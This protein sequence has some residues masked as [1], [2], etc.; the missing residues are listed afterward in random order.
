MFE[1]HELGI[2]K[3]AG[4]RWGG[5]GGSAFIG[6]VVSSTKI[7]FMPTNKRCL[8]NVYDIWKCIKALK[9]RITI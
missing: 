1:S 9:N 5:G 7:K 3:H 8:Y 2:D 6:N 4:G